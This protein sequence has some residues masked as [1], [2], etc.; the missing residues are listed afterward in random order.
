MKSN[1]A[2]ATILKAQGRSKR[3]LAIELGLSPQALDQRLKSQSMRIDTLCETIDKLGYR[4]LLVS[5]DPASPDISIE[6]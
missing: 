2:I 3:S 5:D 4:T 6:G 1:E